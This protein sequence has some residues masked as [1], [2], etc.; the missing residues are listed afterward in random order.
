MKLNARW[1]G[2]SQPM[3]DVCPQFETRFTLTKDV[4]SAMLRVTAMGVYEAR[5]NGRRVGD[6]ILA[7][8]FT[9]YETRVQVQTYDVTSLLS[10]EN[11][12]SVR[13]GGGWCRNFLDLSHGQYPGEEVALIAELTIIHADG[14]EKT[15][16]TDDT[17]RVR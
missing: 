2:L 11:C 1:I 10:A 15:I 8:G 14:T 4:Q 3:G 5:I 7:P 13:V 6:F 12:L 9:S 16:S 17:W